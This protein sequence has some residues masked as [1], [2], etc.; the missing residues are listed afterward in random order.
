MEEDDTIIIQVIFKLE[1]GRQYTFDVDRTTTLYETKKILSNAAHIL[2]NSFT[3]YYEGQEYSKEYEEQ[4]LQ[5]IFPHKKKI[6]FYLKLRK[7]EEELDENENEQISVKYNIKEPCKK[8]LGKF[9]VLYCV[10]CKKSICNECF[11]ISH[12][13]HEVEEKADYLMPAK[14]LMERIFSNSFI[15]KSDPKLSNYMS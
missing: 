13:N 12:N 9:L 11:S 7:K 1:D 4:S 2:K 15:F 3:L 8:H 5:N 6:E 10:S 14:I